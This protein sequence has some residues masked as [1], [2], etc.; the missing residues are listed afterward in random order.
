M[1]FTS[2]RLHFGLCTAVLQLFQANNYSMLIVAV[3]QAIPDKQLFH[4]DYSV[5]QAIPGKQLLQADYCCF[6]ATPGKQLFQAD[7][8]SF[9]AIPGNHLF[10]AD[11][12]RHVDERASTDEIWPTNF[13][14]WTTYEERISTSFGINFATDEV[15]RMKFDERM[16]STNVLDECAWQMCLANVTDMGYDMTSS[17][18]L[19]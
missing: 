7:Y 14:K 10:Q 17:K 12:W 19:L 1:R 15:G 5:S 3:S 6:T 9:T 16:C 18:H 13:E 11:Y 8:C 2:F 4:T